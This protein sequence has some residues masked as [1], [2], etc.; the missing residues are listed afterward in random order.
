[1]IHTE[2]VHH[3][4]LELAKDAPALCRQHLLDLQKAADERG[5]STQS[6]IILEILTQEQERKKLRRINYTTRP[7][8]GRNPLT[9]RVQVS[10][11]VNKYD[12]KQ[13]V[14]DHTSE[15][16]SE[17]FCL[18]YSAPCYQGQLFDDLGFMG[19]TECSKQ[20]LEGTYEYP[21]AWLGI[22]IFGSDFWHPHCK[23]NSDSVFDSKDSGWI[24]FVKF[25]C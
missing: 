11:V 12:T 4:L 5:V 20:I 1:M 6:A 9:L 7:P 21:P 16:L 17:C 18:A 3:K 14:V 13:E 10:T 8:Q 15:H 2:I 25:C 22:L 23:R 24:F 19:Y